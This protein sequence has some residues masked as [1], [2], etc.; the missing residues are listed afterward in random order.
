M[1]IVLCTSPYRC[2]TPYTT[3]RHSYFRLTVLGAPQ[4]HP[5][6]RPPHLLGGP[7]L[8]PHLVPCSNILSSNCRRC[9]PYHLNLGHYRVSPGAVPKKINPSHYLDS[10]SLPP[11]VSGGKRSD[12]Q[13]VQLR[14]IE[15]NHL[16]SLRRGRV[17][18]N[19]QANAKIYS[20]CVMVPTRFSGLAVNERGFKIELLRM[21]IN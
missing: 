4:T 10:S 5:F 17:R 16:S 9:Y 19:S 13:L 20:G 3:V 1:S 11:Q 21:G 12:T 2:L 8:P 15:N 6:H 14:A 18:S 7:Y